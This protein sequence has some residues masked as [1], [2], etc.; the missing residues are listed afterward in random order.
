M[1]RCLLIRLH[2]F[3]WHGSVLA[4]PGR[5]IPHQHKF[6]QMCR[7]PSQFYYNVRDVRTN[8]DTLITVKLMLFFELVDVNV[9]VHVRYTHPHHSH[10]HFP[11]SLYPPLI[12]PSTSSL[13]PLSPLI[14]LLLSLLFLSSLLSPFSSYLY[15]TPLTSLFPLLIKPIPTLLMCYIPSL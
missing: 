12:C 14:S 15:T 6:T 13:L 2:Q 10:L 1:H 4:D 7:V 3:D 5:F 11:S 8:D 9:M